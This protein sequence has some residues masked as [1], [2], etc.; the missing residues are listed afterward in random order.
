MKYLLDNQLAPVTFGIGF[1]EAPFDRVSR[2]FVPWSTAILESY[3]LEHS[4][5]V[6]Q[7]TLKD[8]LAGLFPV[9]TPPSRD[10]LIETSRGWTACFDNSFIGGNASSRSSY[11][12]REL[13]C[14]GVAISATPHVQPIGDRGVYG[15][16]TFDLF[17]SHE[18][19][20]LNQVRSVRLVNDDRWV[21]STSG[22]VQSFEEPDKYKSVSASDRFTPE[23]LERYCRALGIDVFN[24]DFY[25]PNAVM[26][27]KITPITGGSRP[28]SLEEARRNLG[29]VY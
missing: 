7:G 1:V 26:V 29:L 18:T 19:H 6:L 15:A 8:L 12:A 4:V 28:L 9:T 16:V 10:L 2:F 14:R 17:A 25:G 13:E 20:F 3:G 5:S 21:F 11:L 22:P 24:P 23:M 27:A